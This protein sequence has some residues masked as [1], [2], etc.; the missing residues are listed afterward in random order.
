MGTSPSK[1]TTHSATAIFGGMPKGIDAHLDRMTESQ[2]QRVLLHVN[3]IA[4]SMNRTGLSVLN[5]KGVR[6][7]GG[8]FKIT[9]TVAC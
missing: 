2:R 6:S 8:K 5:F 9:S 7:D 1:P 3:K 4:D